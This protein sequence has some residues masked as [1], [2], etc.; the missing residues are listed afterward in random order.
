M[1]MSSHASTDCAA[2]IRS[3]TGTAIDLREPLGFVDLG[4][5]SVHCK[6]PES[7]PDPTIMTCGSSGATPGT[8]RVYL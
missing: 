3:P 5:L 7:P 1:S 2:Q 6:V 4:F 8:V